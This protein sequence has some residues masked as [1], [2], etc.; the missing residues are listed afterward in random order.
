VSVGTGTEFLF[1]NVTCSE[2][3]VE[4]LTLEAN[5]SAPEGLEF[6]EDNLPSSFKYLIAIIDGNELAHQVVN[7]N[8]FAEPVIAYEEPKEDP[9]LGEYPNKIYWVWKVT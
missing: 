8:L 4:S 2:T 5:T 1:L 9:E 6:E 7:Q 3:G